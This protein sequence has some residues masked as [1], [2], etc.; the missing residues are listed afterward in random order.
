MYGDAFSVPFILSWLKV[1]L[2]YLFYRKKVKIMIFSVRRPQ[3]FISHTKSQRLLVT[4]DRLSCEKVNLHN[5]LVLWAWDA[6]DIS[7]QY[8]SKKKEHGKTFYYHYVQKDFPPGQTASSFKIDLF[9]K[10]QNTVK[11]S[12][13]SQQNPQVIT[14]SRF[15]YKS[16]CWPLLSALLLKGD[17][18][19]EARG[20]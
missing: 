7:E 6:C 11:L 5:R 20:P 17:F 12:E 15:S 1:S 8:D 4:R 16:F 18:S 3:Y 13:W 10:A 14:R 9:G 19:L 2:L